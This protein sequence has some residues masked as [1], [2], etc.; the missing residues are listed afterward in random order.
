M[1]EIQTRRSKRTR[2]GIKRQAR[3][4]KETGNRVKK[5]RQKEGSVKRQ[6]RGEAL[7]IDRQKGGVK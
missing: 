7:K 3:G 4:S 1:Q 2:K 6:A 5:D